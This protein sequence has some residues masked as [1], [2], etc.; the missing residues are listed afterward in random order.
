LRQLRFNW[1]A[2]ANR[3]NQWV[4]GYNPERQREFLTRLGM[5]SPDWQNMATTLFWMVGGF[6]TLIALFILRRR[7]SKDP[8]QRVWLAFCAK[9]ARAGTERRPSEGPAAFADRAARAHPARAVMVDAIARLYTDLRY[10]P[11]RDPD[12][13]A[14]LARMVREFKA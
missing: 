7:L 2:L 13:L 10:G 5:P 1:E 9:L 11:Q 3:W 4:L 14:R 12:G 6:V 8:V